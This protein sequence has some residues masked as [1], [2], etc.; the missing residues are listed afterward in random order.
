[1][2]QSK[3]GKFVDKHTEGILIAMLSYL[4]GVVTTYFIFMFTM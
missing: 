1:M 3:L 2:K 4:I